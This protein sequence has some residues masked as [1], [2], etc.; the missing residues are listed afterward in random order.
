MR[1]LVVRPV[2]G[3]TVGD[4]EVDVG[5]ELL[6]VVVLV[7]TELLFDSA[8]VHWLLDDLMVVWDAPL[9]DV[10]WLEELNGVLA[11]HQARKDA[12]SCLR[13]VAI[14]RAVSVLL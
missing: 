4:N 5:L 11:V 9:G 13:P 8:E 14:D 2:E 6:C 7:E 10:N 1:N 3:D 12:L